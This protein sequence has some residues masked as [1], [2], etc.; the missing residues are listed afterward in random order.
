MET[1][2]LLAAGRSVDHLYYVLC[3]SFL[4]GGFA[5]MFFASENLRKGIVN[6][7]ISTLFLAIIGISLLYYGFSSLVDFYNGSQETIDQILENAD[8]IASI[9]R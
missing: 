6:T 5:A 9:F 4:V 8:S 7:W 1:F 3:A 2:I